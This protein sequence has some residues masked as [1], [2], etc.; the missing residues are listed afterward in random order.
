M[1][2]RIFGSGLALFIGFASLL[3]PS[4]Y[5]INPNARIHSKNPNVKTQITNEV[6][7]PKCQK[8]VSCRVGS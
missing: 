7:M 1:K 8:Y 2:S 5:Q 4:R 3:H 6:Q